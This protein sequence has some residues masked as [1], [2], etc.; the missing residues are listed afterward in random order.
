MEKAPCISIITVVRNDRD[1]IDSTIRSVL[2]QTYRNIQYIIVD[3]A[4]SDGTTDII[5]GH[6]N[7]I[8]VLISE[9]DKGI[10]DAMNKGL[11]RVTGDY[12]LFLNSGDRLYENTTLETIFSQG[13]ADVYYGDT[14][15]YDQ[16]QNY[17]GLR[18]QI[19]TRLLP[20]NLSYRNFLMG[21]PVS[22]QSLIVRSGL[23]DEYRTEYFC[24][25][26]IDWCIRLLKKSAKII[27]TH[28]IISGYMTGGHSH[29]HIRKC[30]AE[31]FKIMYLHFGIIQACIAQAR[32]ALRYIYKRVLLNKK[33]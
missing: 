9:P 3:G 23:T 32:I 4:S 18:S 24:S 2:D 30:W 7:R 5:R 16:K 31:R 33:Y 29:R 25:A 12:V 28:T 10:Y 8:D 17:L 26:D 14:A 22:H 11:K 1:H 19:S 13:E 6:G 15:F 27:N 21:M 20:E